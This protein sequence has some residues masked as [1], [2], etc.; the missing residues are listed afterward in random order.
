MKR[1]P[2]RIAI[3]GLGLIGGSLALALKEKGYEIVGITKKLKT[4]KIA[5]KKKAINFGYTKLSKESLKGVDVIFLSTPLTYIPQYIKDIG[6]LI[7]DK[8]ILTDV[9]STK[10]EI[11]N[12]AKK[13]LPENIIFIGGHPMAGNENS[14][15]LASEKSL[16]KNCAW[17]LTPSTLSTPHKND[18]KTKQ[19]IKVLENIITK[20]GAKT[21]I[22]NSKEHDEAVAL[23]SHLPLLASIGLCQ[24]VRKI[25]NTKLK[26]LAQL[27][28]SSGFRDTTRISSGNAI[29]NSGLLTSNFPNLVKLLPEYK[30]EL[31]KLIK[32]ANKNPTLVKKTLEEVS[33]WR[34]HLYNT[35]GKNSLLHFHTFTQP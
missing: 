32:S 11:C 21:I 23:I 1:K 24:L 33:K 5:K 31:D 28:A 13:F 3:I 4:I 18:K 27:I 29:M 14:S 16:F 15:F 12:S 2:K 10:F 6:K 30:I 8:V 20:T 35:E 19:A 34:S 17:I 9:G 22:T 7:K 25:T 26:K